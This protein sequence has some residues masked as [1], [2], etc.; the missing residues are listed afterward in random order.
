[1]ILHIDGDAFFVGCELTRRPDLFGKPVVTGAERGIASAMSYE[2]KALG[3]MRGYPIF[4][5]RKEFP[6]VVVLPGDYELYEQMSRRMYAI[7][8]RFSDRVEE[9]SID[10]CFALL[11]QDYAGQ[12]R[13]IKNTLASELDMTFSVG[14]APTKVLAKLA[15]KRD[16]PDGCVVVSPQNIE[17]ELYNMSIDRVWGIGRASVPLM[18]ALGVNTV[19]DFAGQSEA[20]VRSY[21]HTPMLVLWREIKGESVMKVGEGDLAKHKSIQKT[22]TFSPPTS[23]QNVLMSQLAKNCE[24]AFSY[25]RALNLATSEISF[26]IKSDKFKYHTQNFKL[27]ALTQTPEP[28]LAYI[29][30][31]LFALMR[32]GEKYRA[33]GITLINLTEVK[34]SRKF[35]FRASVCEICLA[36]IRKM[37]NIWK[38]T[39]LQIVCMRNM[40]EE[41]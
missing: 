35:N 5:L 7:M 3:I 16:K 17:K 2:A 34:L 30:E 36:S 41:C 23:D 33:T 4:K 31:H 29:R 11:R 25:A 6:D 20:W 21:F 24:N 1:M 15:S 12:A 27:V 13:E 32:T 9:Y 26:F 18:R 39:K 37:T 8:R 14:L 38:P 10:E 19:G 28:V 22:R 40:V